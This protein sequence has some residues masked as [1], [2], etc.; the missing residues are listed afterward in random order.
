MAAIWIAFEQPQR[1][2]THRVMREM[3][4]GIKSS[5]AVLRSGMTR[6]MTE[7]GTSIEVEEDA[8]AEL[9]GLMGQE[10]IVS[11]EAQG[12]EEQ[13]L[14]V[15]ATIRSIKA[16]DNKK[17]LLGL[18]FVD[19]DQNDMLRLVRMA[20]CEPGTWMRFNEPNDSPLRSF[21]KLAST[22][23]RVMSNSLPRSRK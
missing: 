17:T 7:Y 8:A 9:T 23:A 21:W 13:G 22:P 14:D 6:E 11:F 19:P 20:Y 10:V 4:V 3:P 15:N 2:K 1:R 16:M 5:S 18:E 12:S